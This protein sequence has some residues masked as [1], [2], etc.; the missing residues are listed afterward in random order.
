MNRT[1]FSINDILK[2][3]KVNSESASVPPSLKA[4][5]YE[6]FAK[7]K[8]QFSMPSMMNS[9]AQ[10]RQAYK[11]PF[12]AE[13]YLQKQQILWLHYW[14]NFHREFMTAANRNNAKQPRGS[15]YKNVVL[16]R[17]RKSQLSLKDIENS[18]EDVYERKINTMTRGTTDTGRH[19]EI[20][21]TSTKIPT[22]QSPLKELE[23]L[24]TSTL[25]G[26]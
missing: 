25:P 12:L 3:D 22:F 18:K 24:T 10:R 6:D 9:I 17:T 1:P 16:P 7:L 19:R 4:L 20:P 11:L 13:D 23:K 8:S 2:L 15:L 26:I 14:Y 21:I 5:S